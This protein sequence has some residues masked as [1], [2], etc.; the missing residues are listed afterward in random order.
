MTK[1]HL[2]QFITMT[3]YNIEGKK[4][5][6]VSACRCPHLT[7]STKQK[8]IVPPRPLRPVV[9]KDSWRPAARAWRRGAHSQFTSE[10]IKTPEF[11]LHTC[12]GLSTGDL[13]FFSVYNSLSKQSKGVYVIMKQLYP[14]SSCS[15][16]S[17]KVCNKAFH[18]EFIGH[19]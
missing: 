8:G 18:G 17:V 15:P 6:R 12:R 7:A 1:A 3:V 16:W 14:L 13:C 9:L 11:K 19:K 10:K 4:H 2:Q 5:Q